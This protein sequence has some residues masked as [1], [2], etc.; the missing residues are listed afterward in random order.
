M[1]A[2]KVVARYTDGRVIKGFTQDFFPNKD[3]FHLILNENP[4]TVEV[5]VQRLKAVF[6]VRDFSG[7]SQYQE[8]KRYLQGE[9]PGGVKLEVTFAD[10]EVLVGSTPLGYDPKRQG[11]FVTPVDPGSNN[12]KVFVVGSA[13]RGVR[14]LFDYLLE[15]G[16]L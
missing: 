10:G 3:R 5:L 9:N 16:T 1:G 14:Q 6:F 13:V 8:R 7:N 15:S 4:R 12:S 2:A 11:F